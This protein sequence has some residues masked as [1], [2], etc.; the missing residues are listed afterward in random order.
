MSLDD[1]YLPSAKRKKLAEEVHPLLATRGVPGTH[2]IE[3]LN[4]VLTKLANNEVGFS[5]PKF[6]KGTDEPCKE[7]TWYKVDK[8]VDIVL[9]EGWCWGT[10]PQTTEQLKLPVNELE[11]HKDSD[12]V[13]RNY[14]NEQLIEK[15]QPLYKK[16]NYWLVLQAP[17]F[18]CVYKWRLEQEEKLK[19]R[20]SNLS[21]AQS[22]IMNP[23]QILNF[24]QYFQRLSVQG[25]NT[26]SQS[27]D[28]VLY[29]DNNRTIT[30]MVLKG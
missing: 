30:K 21:E 4:N 12:A 11:F 6:N 15:Y 17:S 23:E 5:I 26:L 10:M 28:A 25:I 8:P 2:D 9:L 3:A 20:M 22:K 18:D 24:T 13:W 7:S 14:V 29:L 27:A 1:F 16:M 19:A